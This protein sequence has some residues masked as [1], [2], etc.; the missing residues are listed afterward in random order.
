MNRRSGTGGLSQACWPRVAL[1]MAASAMF[2]PTNAQTNNSLPAPERLSFWSPAEQEYGYR[3]MERIFPTNVIRRGSAVAALPVDPAGEM[4]VQLELLNRRYT[5]DDFVSLSRSS[6]VLVVQDGKV[7]AERYALGRKP[8]DR[9]TSFSVAKSVTSTLVGAAIQDGFIGSVDEQVTKYLPQMKGSAYDGVTIKHLLT[10]T[11]GVKWRADYDDPE[12]DFN[13]YGTDMGAA[14]L[15]AMG[16]MPRVHAPGEKFGYSTA[17]SNM[18]GAVVI[19]ATGRSLSDYLSE[20]IWAP[21]GME[22]DG[23]WMTSKTG[24][25]TGGICF[26]ATLKDYARFG[27]FILADGVVNGKRVLPEGWIAEATRPHSQNVVGTMGYGY[28]WWTHPNGAFKGIGIMGQ[29]LHID[30]SRGLII[31]IQSAWRRYSEQADRDLVDAFIE[32]VT[33]SVDARREVAH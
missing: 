14:F 32:A 13:K 9:W 22:Q 31:V 19:A 30:P 23:F 11:S 25:E 28:Q 24:E 18:L 15:E 6:G 33:K 29:Y 1:V 10:M 21:F 26:S 17:Q 12:S 7:L 16:K 2:N 8:Q 5:I 3:S 20:K 4:R 27:M